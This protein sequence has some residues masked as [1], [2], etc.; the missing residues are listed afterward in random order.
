MHKGRDISA[1]QR[2]VLDAGTNNVPLRDRDDVRDTITGVNDRTRQRS[3]LH[4]LRRPGRRQRQ[5]GLH[6]DVQPGHLCGNQ[7]VSLETHVFG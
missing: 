7:P 1:S 4:V 3:L 6:G 2:D 5:H